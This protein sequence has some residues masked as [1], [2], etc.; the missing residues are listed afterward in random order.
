[1][2]L[3]DVA[4]VTFRF[5]GNTFRRKAMIDRQRCHPPECWF[6]LNMRDLDEVSHVTKVFHRW[7]GALR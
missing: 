5:G 2:G 1:M 4:W 3:N 6:P 7:K